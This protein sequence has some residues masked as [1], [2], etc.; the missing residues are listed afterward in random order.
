V[1]VDLPAMKK[2]IPA[3]IFGK[4]FLNQL[5]KILTGVPPKKGGVLDEIWN[6]TFALIGFFKNK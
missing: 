1:E 3:K 4:C 6:S 5:I 2:Q